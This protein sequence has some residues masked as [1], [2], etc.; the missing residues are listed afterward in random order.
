MAI[1]V[2]RGNKMLT[3]KAR[4]ELIDGSLEELREE[5]YRTREATSYVLDAL[6]ELDRLLSINQT[7]HKIM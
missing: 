6:W 3:L 4:E 1:V 5:L 2:P 7:H